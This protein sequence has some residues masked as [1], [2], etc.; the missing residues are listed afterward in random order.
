MN[1]GSVQAAY[2]APKVL[3]V[4]A[5]KTASA[6]DDNHQVHAASLTYYFALPWPCFVQALGVFV[7][8]PESPLQLHAEGTLTFPIFPV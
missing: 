6:G 8:F 7:P 5:S 2:S 4:A 1:V 3:I